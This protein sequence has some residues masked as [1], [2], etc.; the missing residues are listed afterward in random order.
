MKKIKHT[1]L[2]VETATLKNLVRALQPADPKIVRG[3]NAAGSYY[4]CQKRTA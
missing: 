4:T 3:G 1:K 2:T